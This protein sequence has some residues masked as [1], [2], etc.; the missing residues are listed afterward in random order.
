MRDQASGEGYP[1]TPGE[2]FE[3]WWRRFQAT[4]RIAPLRLGATRAEVHRLLGEPDDTG[5]TS[6]RQRLPLIWRYGEVEFHFEPGG[7]GG[8][9]LIYRESVDG[10]PVLSLAARRGTPP[11]RETRGGTP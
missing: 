5:G 2:G 6:R 7:N 1:D 8:L 11:T 4:G 3:R 9:W 10:E